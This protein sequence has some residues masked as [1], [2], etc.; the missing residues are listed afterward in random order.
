[1]GYATPPANYNTNSICNP[2]KINIVSR[3]Y[4]SHNRRVT[5]SEVVEVKDCSCVRVI[6]VA[7]DAHR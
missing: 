2:I 1:M 4:I 3:I 7:C 5:Y 6:S